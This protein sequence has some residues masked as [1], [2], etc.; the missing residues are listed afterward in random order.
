MM[1]DLPPPRTR[2]PLDAIHH[3]FNKLTS[4]IPIED[5]VGIPL[6]VTQICAHEG[7]KLPFA[8]LPHLFPLTTLLF[9]WLSMMALP[10]AGEGQYKQAFQ[11]RLWW[12]KHTRQTKDLR[13]ITRSDCESPFLSES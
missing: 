12:S 13:A 7:A 8:S 1:A 5:H 3:L 4:P 11:L 2:D 6:C 9:G 10:G